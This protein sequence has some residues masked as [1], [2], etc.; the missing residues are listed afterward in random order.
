MISN[1]EWLCLRGFLSKKVVVASRNKI[2]RLPNDQQQQI[3]LSICY[4]TAPPTFAGTLADDDEMIDRSTARTVEQRRFVL[5][6]VESLDHQFAFNNWTIE[7][8]VDWL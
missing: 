2:H 1:D 8:L 5:G 7:W 4:R 3:T 6:T